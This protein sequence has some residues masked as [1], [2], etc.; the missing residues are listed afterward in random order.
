[1]TDHQRVD[2]TVVTLTRHRPDLLERAIRSVEDQRTTAAL[3]HLVL[4]DDCPTTARLLAARPP[5]RVPLRHESHGRSARVQSAPAWC[6]ALRNHGARAARG[7]WIAFLDDDNELAPDHLDAL[8]ATAAACDVRAV[9]SWLRLRNRD[10]TPFTE[11]RDPWRRD[12]AASHARYQWAL[13]RGV[14]TPGSPIVRDRCDAPGTPDP[15]RTVDTGEWLLR[16]D[17]L[18]AVPFPTDLA[19][20]D[21]SG[22][23]YG[24]DDALLDSLVALGE[25]VA[26][27]RR[28]TLLYTLGGYSNAPD[29]ANAAVEP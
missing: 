22:S 28:A 14:R 19:G 25:P 24:E 21:R 7:R 15:V 8:L 26:C 4:V 1:V 18:L 16:R 20:R 2:V 23:V 3:E 5:G 17:L 6:A 13:D 27:S 10:G 11:P 12:P 29:E 9:H